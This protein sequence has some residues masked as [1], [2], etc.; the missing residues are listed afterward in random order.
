MSN[1]KHISLEEINMIILSIKNFASMYGPNAINEDECLSLVEG[2]IKLGKDQNIAILE[3]LR[4]LLEQADKEEMKQHMFQYIDNKLSNNGKVPLNKRFEEI[5]NALSIAEEFL[6]DSFFETLINKDKRVKDIISKFTKEQLEEIKNGNVDI[7]SPNEFFERC[8]RVYCREN[9][10]DLPKEKYPQ[11]TIDEEIEL[12]DKV[13]EGNE[14]SR[15]EFIGRLYRVVLRES[16]KSHPVIDLPLTETVKHATEG[17]NETLSHYV[18]GDN[19]RLSTL[20]KVFI[21]RA[22]Y[23][24]ENNRI[25]ELNINYLSSRFF[26]EIIEVME[27]KRTNLDSVRLPV[28]VMNRYEELDKAKV[29]KAIETMKGINFQ[30]KGSLSLVLTPPKPEEI[31]INK[32]A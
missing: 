18:Q 26:R 23:E 29:N 10:I 5:G 25:H 24:A 32:A 19:I 7:V 16:I 8:V 2:K 3:T 20:S 28:Y 22:I 4:R 17:I 12:F 14:A 11:L 31:F 21:D 1:T 6:D 30:D 9:G 15:I 13:K 27:S